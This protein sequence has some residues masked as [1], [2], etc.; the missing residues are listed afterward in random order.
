[1]E[2]IAARLEEEEGGSA[3]SYGSI[4]GLAQNASLAGGAL[5]EGALAGPS[6]ISEA[7][8]ALDGEERDLIEIGDGGYALIWIDRIEE[9]ALMPLDDV[10][11]RAIA[12]WQ[13]AERLAA[14]T[15]QAEELVPRMDA[16][17]SVW[18]LGEEFGA[19]VLP[20]GP[21]SRVTPPPGIPAT[22]VEKAF[23]GA[24]AEG[25][26]AASEDG[27]QV[28]IAQITTVFPLSPEQMGQA[29]SELDQV[30]ASTLRADTIEYFARA[31][32]AQHP[33]YVDPEVVESVF[34]ALGAVGAGHNNP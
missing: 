26:F 22:L 34:S 17:T 6:F 7:F 27:S 12:A 32:E 23:E 16:E 21:F 31:V 30:L 8:E 14:L 15:A 9:S 29:S 1:M 10:R 18:V 2:E 5:A 28:F 20:H 3:I 19:I 25:I 4:D 33:A 24:E 11:D 13:R